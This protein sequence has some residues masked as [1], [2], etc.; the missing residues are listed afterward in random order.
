[1]TKKFRKPIALLIAVIMTVTMVM[2]API[3]SAASYDSAAAATEDLEN[4]WSNDGHYEYFYDQLTA[5]A[6][7][8]YNAMKEMYN[9]NIFKNGGSY[10]L[11][12]NDVVTQAQL[13]SYASGNNA[14]LNT[15]GAA[16]DAF[17][18][19]YPEVFY[20]NTDNLTI[21][22]KHNAQT[23]YKA[24]LG[25]EPTIITEKALKALN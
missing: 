25:A 1:M 14:L 21:T 23:G 18:A 22:V 15:Y 6:K 8:F 11:V 12:A 13:E 2:T 7:K 9:Q 4:F 24:S 19:D 10:D 17:F 16:R 5:D 3:V 20:V